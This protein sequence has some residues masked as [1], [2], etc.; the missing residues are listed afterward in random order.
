MLRKIELTISILIL[1]VIVGITIFWLSGNTNFEN[2]NESSE[3]IS[4]FEIEDLVP[5]KFTNGVIYGYGKD[6]IIGMDVYG[7]EIISME[8]PADN[9]TSVD[10]N[11]MPYNKRSFAVSENTFYYSDSEGIYFAENE[12]EKFRLILNK[13][14]VAVLQES[15]SIVD[16]AVNLKGEIYIL[17]I[18]GADEEWPTD[19]FIINQ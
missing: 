13:N 18:A 10:Y 17:A 4:A 11:G 7:N 15:Y 19:L 2:I 14:E 16:M 6:S 9:K 1:M 5:D 12:D 3:Y 8:V